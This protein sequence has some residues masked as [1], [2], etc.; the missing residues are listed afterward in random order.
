M[1]ELADDDFLITKD[2]NTTSELDEFEELELEEVNSE[3]LDESSL[4]DEVKNIENMNLNLDQKPETQE[5]ITIDYNKNQV[6]HEIGIDDESFNELFQDYLNESQV[7]TKV[8]N[9]AIEQNDSTIWKKVAIK[10]K[11][12]SDNMR[13]HDFSNEV[14]TLID[15]TDVETAKHAIKTINATLE[16]ISKIEG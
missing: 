1:V 2:E 6:A 14:Q 8:I 16:Q 5:K 9:D 3:E 13:I 7:S 11:G 12:M 10:L 4:S 15:T